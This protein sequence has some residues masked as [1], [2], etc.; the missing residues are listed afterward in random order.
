MI[1]VDRFGNLV[2][3]FSAAEFPQVADG[4]FEMAIGMT[5]LRQ[6]VSSYAE[7]AAGE[8]FLIGGSS[9]YFEVSVNQGSAAKLLGC[10]VGAPV[11]LTVY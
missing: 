10:G 3:N 1:Q 6:V 7:C 11:E 9:G 4:K 8:P 2:T 5:V